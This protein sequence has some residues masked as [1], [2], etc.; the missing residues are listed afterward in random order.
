MSR[1]T[2]AARWAA[3][4]WPLV[5]FTAM[6]TIGAGLVLTPIGALAVRS[7]TAAA[8]SLAGGGALLMALALAVSLA[9]L[10]RPLR[11]ARAAA[12]LG[13]SRLSA[14]IAFALATVA[15]ASISFAWPALPGAGIVAGLLACGLLVSLGLVYALPNQPAWR[16]PAAASPLAMAL[17]LAVF[18]LAARGGN[19]LGAWQPVVA[20]LLAADLGL[21]AWRALRLSATPPWCEPTQP[22]WFRHRAV[23]LALRVTLVTLVPLLFA[24]AGRPLAA[25]IALA[26]GILVDRVNFYALAVRRTTESEIA[27]AEAA[28]AP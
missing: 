5:L 12:N 27:A 26:F 13:Q 28:I 7:G 23:L 3:D 1:A 16:G 19:P 17:P 24:L 15:A 8:V 6:A 2:K 11:A 22:E 20:V 14:E 10:G 9:H 21:F 25:A 18:A 4:D